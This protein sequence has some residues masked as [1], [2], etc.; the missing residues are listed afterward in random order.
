MRCA[1]VLLLLHGTDAICAEYIPSKLFEYLW[2]QRPILALVHENAQMAA[3]L[4]AQNHVVIQTKQE[5][6]RGYVTEQALSEGIMV[7]AHAW[8]HG[9][10]LE[11]GRSSPYSTGAAVRQMLDWQRP[12]TGALR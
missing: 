5:T 1:E 3:M 4:S 12:L 8:L 9:D 7:L 11:R 6:E 2:M 10:D